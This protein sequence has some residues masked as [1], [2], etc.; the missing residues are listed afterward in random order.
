MVQGM[1][2]REYGTLPATLLSLLFASA[3]AAA[4]PRAATLSG[5][6]ATEV[7]PRASRVVMA[8][9]G[10]AEESNQTR[11]LNQPQ[12]WQLR[13][14]YEYL[15]GMEP[16]SGKMVPQLATEWT[17][18]PNGLA[19]RFK[20]RK[21]VQFHGGWG[22]F[23]AK[24]VVYTWKDFT[25]EDSVHGQAPQFRKGV[26]DIEIINDYEV[27]I[28]LTEPDGN[29]LH[30]LGEAEGGMEIISKAHFDGKGVP[31]MQTE[32]YAGTGPYRFKERAQGSFIRFERVPFQHWRAI[33]DFP[34][35]EFR[36][37]K[38]SSTRLAALLTGEV[39]GRP[40]C[41]GRTA[42]YEGGA[43][44]SCRT[45]DLHENPLLQLRGPPRSL[46]GL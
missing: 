1:A 2:K 30:A 3:C 21:G 16:Q 46:Q 34:E 5:A 40:A 25:Q 7:Q 37:L 24:D 13:P 11:H 39:H 22:E 20:L 27:I 6:G 43:W 28:H 31:T 41:P 17:L 19:F 4:E 10:P 36:F 9:P 23:T 33:P 35:F 26:R 18:E 44:A 15:L 14:M 29:F 42:G 45:Q 8:L 32:P 12:V 38:E